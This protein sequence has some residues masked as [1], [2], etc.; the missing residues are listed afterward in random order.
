MKK[1]MSST[2]KLTIKPTLMKK[3]KIDDIKEYIQEYKTDLS[4][5]IR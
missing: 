3:S 5:Q 2:K 1:F 4:K